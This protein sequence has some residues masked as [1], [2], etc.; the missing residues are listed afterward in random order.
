GITSR[1]VRSIVRKARELVLDCGE[2]GLAQFG[3]ST[4]ISTRRSLTAWVACD[5]TS[6]TVSPVLIRKLMTARAWAGKT[7]SLTPPS[8]KVAAVV[9]R[10]I[11]LVVGALSS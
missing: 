9:V 6:L 1:I 4:R 3:S 5:N 11:A 2:A 8:N 10:R 7:L